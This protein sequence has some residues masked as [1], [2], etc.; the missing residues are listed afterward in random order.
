VRAA[1][2]LVL[3]ACGSPAAPAPSSPSSPPAR[4]PVALTYFGV[5]GWQLEGAGRVILADPYFSRPIHDG[6]PISPDLE[7]IAARAPAKADLITIG[8]SH[9]DHL[10]D[11][12]EVARRTGATLLGSLTTAMIGRASGLPEEQLITVKGGED[13]AFDGFSVRVIPSLHSALDDKHVFGGALTEPP[14]LPMPSSDWPEGGTFAYLVRL[15][16]HEILMLSTANFI[17]RELEGLR[18]DIAIIGVGLRQEIYDY[19]CRLLHALGDPP[20]VY[21]NHFDDWHAPPVDV[22][23]DEDLLAFVAEVEACAP[24]TIVTIPRHFER[25]VVL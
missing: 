12:P 23:P 9:I 3:A 8:H 5:A 24:G 21:A 18:P 4:D 13:F 25:M 17:E 7:A 1:L 11:A 22:P 20:R 19:T 10:L 2:L 15:A 14:T 16:G 6:G